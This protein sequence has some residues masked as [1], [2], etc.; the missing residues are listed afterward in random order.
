MN[1]AAVMAADSATVQFS[2]AGKVSC[3]AV[4]TTKI[5]LIE[6]QLFNQ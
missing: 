6:S 5:L 3:G 4:F 2:I 1:N